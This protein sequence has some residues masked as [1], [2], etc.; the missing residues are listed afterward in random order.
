MITTSSTVL[1][2]PVRIALDRGVV[3]PAMPLALTADRKLDTCRQRALARVDESRGPN[4][5]R[6]PRSYPSYP[7]SLYAFVEKASAK[8]GWSPAATDENF[9]IGCQAGLQD[10][11]TCAVTGA[12][13][14]SDLELALDT[15]TTI[16]TAYLSDKCKGVEIGMPQL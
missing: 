15:T 9:T 5:E 16:C 7:L 12:Q 2:Q 1:P 10:F 11:I 3:I 6:V 4:P 14:Q 13:P 8:E